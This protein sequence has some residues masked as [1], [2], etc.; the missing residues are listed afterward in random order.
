MYDLAAYSFDLK[1]ATLVYIN[2]NS[3]NPNNWQ[4]M[5]KIPSSQYDWDN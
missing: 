3:H 1:K 5:W 2:N 4:G